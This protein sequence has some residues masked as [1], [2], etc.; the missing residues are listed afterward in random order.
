[1]DKKLKK[2]LESLMEGY[3]TYLFNPAN[4]SEI[5][6]KEAGEII[7]KEI[8]NSAKED[9]PGII[10]FD[11]W[12][13]VVLRTDLGTICMGKNSLNIVPSSKDERGMFIYSPQDGLGDYQ[14]SIYIEGKK[15]GDQDV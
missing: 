2:R 11:G 7:Q 12:T 4:A 6:L 9:R 1:M 10:I 15:G 3:D 13:H 8:Y 5:N 14:N